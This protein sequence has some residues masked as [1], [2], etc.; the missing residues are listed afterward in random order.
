MLDD[1]VIQLVG[2]LGHQTDGQS[3]D[4]G[5][6]Q[7]RK[8]SQDLDGANTSISSASIN[9]RT[10]YIIADSPRIVQND[11]THHDQLRDDAQDVQMR[12]VGKEEIP[13]MQHLW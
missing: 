1:L 12:A 10:R 13:E 9:L 8:R 4:L 2:N 6:V 3:L 11:I 5:R 7:R